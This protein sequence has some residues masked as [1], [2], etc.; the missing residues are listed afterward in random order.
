M[1]KTVKSPKKTKSG[2]NAGG[3]VKAAKK[4]KAAPAKKKTVSAKKP[5][6]QKNKGF[7]DSF[8]IDG[9]LA[10]PYSYFAGRVGSKFITTIRDQKKIMGVRCPKCNKVYIPPRQT[11]EKDL[12]DIRNNWV[13]LKNTGTVINFT[14]VRYKDRHL[15]KKP[16]YILA[17]V[18]L[19][20]ADTPFAHV[21]EGIKPEKM[22]TGMRVKAVFARETSSTILDIDHFEPFTEEKTVR[23]S[24]RGPAMKTP[25]RAAVTRVDKETDERRKAMSRKVIITAALSGAGTF[26]NQNPAVPYTPA[27]FA[28]EAE[29]CFKAGA[30][31]VHVHAK[32]DDGMPTHEVDRIKATYDAIKQRCPDLIVNLSSAVGMGKTAEQRITQIVQI[33]PEMASLNT[34]TMNFS[35]IDRKSGKIFIDYVFENT[36]SMLQDFGKAMEENGV[37]P[38]IE[39]YDIGGL[40]NT[41]LIMK[42]GFFTTP[43]NFNFVWGVAGGQSFRPE[44]FMAMVHALPP[45]AN[46]T[47]CGVGVEEWP[48]ITL[49]CMIG[50]HMRV[51]LEDNIRVPGGELAKGNYELVEWAVRIAEVFNRVPA[52]PDEAREIMGLRKK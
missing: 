44:S 23:V 24:D 16:P 19:D 52:T 3:K 14:V 39:C 20:G 13:E 36:F 17:L 5:A 32:S 12:T 48:C 41:M 33:K 9:K 46:F 31:M 2:S 47:T 37:K 30:A 15:P 40:D 7:A 38:E 35:I 51:G 28:D 42:Q 4:A 18:K 29:K 25:E 45:G 6:P 8:V 50:G 26:K 11:C 1:R 49:S 43:M 21:V 34:N 27:E 22:S 10:L